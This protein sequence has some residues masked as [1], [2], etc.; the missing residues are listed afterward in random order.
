VTLVLI[1]AT[2]LQPPPLPELQVAGLPADAAAAVGP[3][4]DAARR[5]P[6]DPERVGALAIALHAW[7]QWEL[8]RTSYGRARALAPRELRWWYLA[9]LLETAAGRHADAVPLLTHALELDGRAVTRL[10]LAE[11]LLAAGDL[12]AAAPHFTVL[13]SRPE[14]APAAEYGLGRIAAA[15]RDHA[16]AIDHFRRA[17]TIFP[18]FGAAHYALALSLRATGDAAAAREAIARQ[19][20]CLACWP[21]TPDPVAAAVTAARTD[22]AARLRE[23]LALA[24]DG[25]TDGAIAGHLAVL[26]AAPDTAQAHVNLIALLGRR[27]RWADAE[28]HYRLALQG[29]IN[30]A[31]AHGSYGEVLLAQRRHAEAATAFEAALA[32]TPQFAAARNGL[33]MA[34]EGQRRTAEALAAYRQAVADGPTLRL[35]RFNLAR[36]LIAE[37]R[38]DEAVAELE[39]LQDPVDAETPRYRFAL[40]AALVRAGNVTRG[41]ALAEDALTLARRFGQDTLADTIARDLRRLDGRER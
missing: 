12:D 9:G 10:R 38:L 37:Q 23:A 39:R 14:S 6:D 15:R 17:T 1:L 29:G 41:R 4:Y 22:T 7:E 16:R 30:P 19:Q 13:A 25:D 36:L 31:E 21:A 33:G 27:E 3:V 5:A 34:L 28:R 32:V 18:E 35:A 11:A 8:A 2:L 24:R 26:A 40:A 20:A